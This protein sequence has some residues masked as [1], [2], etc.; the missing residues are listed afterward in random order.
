IEARADDGTWIAY[1]IVTGS[2]RTWARVAVDR[3]VKLTARDVSQ[4]Q[5]QAQHVIEWKGPHNKF[6]VIRLAD[7][8]PIRTGFST[9]DEATAWMREHER[10]LG[11]S[12]A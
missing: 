2:D 5:A 7:R 4:S 8:E 3:V 12:V 11:A 10:M 6:T 1:L 9:K